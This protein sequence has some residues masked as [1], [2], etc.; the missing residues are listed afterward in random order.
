MTSLWSVTG[1]NGHLST[2]SVGAI[3]DQGKHFQNVGITNMFVSLTLGRVRGMLT[4]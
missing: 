4:E 2:D 3:R 1:P